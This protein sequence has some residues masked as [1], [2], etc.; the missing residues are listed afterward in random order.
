MHLNGITLQI[1]KQYYCP[2]QY[3]PSTYTALGLHVLGW[4]WVCILARIILYIP[5][6]HCGIIG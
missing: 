3:Q 6:Y 4:I 5:L 1:L 2:I